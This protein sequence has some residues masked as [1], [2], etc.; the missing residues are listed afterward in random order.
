MFGKWLMRLVMAIYVFLYRRTGGKVGGRL[1]VM[2]VLLLTTTG[3]KTGKKHTVPVM[4]L[5]ESPNYII[6]ASNN[7]GEKPPAWWLNLKGNPQATIEI[8][9]DMKLVTIEQA[10]PEEK[11]RLWVQLVAKAPAFEGYQKRTQR[12]I[13]MVILRPQL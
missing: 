2:P 10:G 1:G 7:G 9:G 12:E 8:G 3:R 11:K 5:S 6:T 13:P 4:Y